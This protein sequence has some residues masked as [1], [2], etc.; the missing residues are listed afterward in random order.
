MTTNTLSSVVGADLVGKPITE[1]ALGSFPKVFSNVSTAQK[2]L[3]KVMSL[4]TTTG[5]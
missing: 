1:V 4:N 2:A 3:R 5:D